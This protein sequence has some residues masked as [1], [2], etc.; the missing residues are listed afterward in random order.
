M[1]MYVRISK[2]DPGGRAVEGVGFR[3]I[4]CWDRGFESCWG[5][6]RSSLVFDLYY[7]GS[8]R[9]DGLITRSEESHQVC[10]CLIVCDLETS[11][12]RRSRPGLC[13][14]AT[15]QQMLVWIWI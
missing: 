13:C 8:A 15:R 3:P 1:L 2:A 5:H 9:C 6:A 7:V 12:M 11:T 4:Y 10:M 14:C